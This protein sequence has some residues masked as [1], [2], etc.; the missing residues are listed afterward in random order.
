MTCNLRL[1]FIALQF[2]ARR[3]LASG[4]AAPM[5]ADLWPAAPRHGG[6]WTLSAALTQMPGLDIPGGR[7]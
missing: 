1:C 3:W 5:R 7:S 4:Q 2:L 6:C